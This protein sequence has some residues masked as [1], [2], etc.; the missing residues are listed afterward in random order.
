MTL[1]NDFSAVLDYL[2]TINVNILTLLQCAAKV[3]QVSVRH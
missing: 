1:D 2:Y 3:W